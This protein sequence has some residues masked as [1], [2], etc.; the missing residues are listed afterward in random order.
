MKILIIQEKGRN[1]QNRE[2]K[3]AL[4][5]VR[6]FYRQFKDIN[7]Q[8]WGLGYKSFNT[9]FMDVVEDSDVILLLENY[10][11]ASWVPDLSKINKLKLFWS[12]DSH[13]VL[14]QHLNTCNHH[15]IDVVLCSNHMDMHHFVALNRGVYSF[16][17]CY[18]SDLVF[19]LNVFKKYD[20]G[21]CGNVNNRLDWLK[22]INQ[23]FGAKIDVMKIGQ[24]IV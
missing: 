10:D 6:A 16:P 2:F 18:P 22:Y 15:K 13:V 14:E 24:D 4:N 21:F 11:S 17:S 8:V 20:V 7:V 23:K 3:E 5:F 19:P 1:D 12:I 9:P